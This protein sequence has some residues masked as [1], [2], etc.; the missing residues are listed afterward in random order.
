MPNVD[1]D[2]LLFI[3]GSD[4]LVDFFKDKDNLLIVM[5]KGFDPRSCKIIE[6]LSN[7]DV[8]F[9]VLLVDYNEQ[10]T[11]GDS[12]KEKSRSEKNFKEFQKLCES[13]PYEELQVPSYKSEND[14][15]RLLVISESVRSAF[16][17]SLIENYDHILLDFS[18]LPRAVAFSIAKHL[19]DTKEEHQKLYLLAC[20]NSE[21]DDYIIPKINEGTAEFLQGFNAFAMTMESENDETIWFPFLGDNEQAAFDIISKYLKPIEI[22]PVVPFP[23]KNIK[24][25]KVLL[26]KYGQKLFKEQNI[27]KR[28]IIYV[29]ECQPLLNAKKLINTV[30]YYE[31]ALNFDNNRHI[32]YAFSAHSSKLMDI[33]LL[34]SVMTL[35][36]HGRKVGIV[37]VDNKGYEVEKDN[38]YEKQKDELYCVCLDYSKFI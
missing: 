19:W 36:Q 6:T 27:E 25:S 23:S 37:V 4:E 12:A 21:Y 10:L 13:I 1:L 33:G 16:K 8:I 34:L 38:S 31:R 30:K 2:D 18:A 11:T 15:K 28:N 32:H 9:N 22:C 14:S 7:N 17:K 5:G 24:R 20:E 29:P 35:L 26:R 3:Q